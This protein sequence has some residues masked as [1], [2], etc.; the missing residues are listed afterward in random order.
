MKRKRPDELPAER[1]PAGISATVPSCGAARFRQQLPA[2][3]CLERRRISRASAWWTSPRPRRLRM[4]LASRT[5]RP[6]PR[7]P[8]M[9]SRCA[10]VWWPAAETAKACGCSISAGSSAAPCGRLLCFAAR[11]FLSRCNNTPCPSLPVPPGLHDDGCGDQEPHGTRASHEQARQHHPPRR[12]QVHRH[13]EEQLLLSAQLE[14]LSTAAAGSGGA[15]ALCGHR[16]QCCWL[17]HAA[18]AA[19][20]LIV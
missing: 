13:A 14:Q 6:P 20:C 19:A 7:T 1:Q 5:L 17:A 15:W 9:W 16:D 10:L 2:V 11:C 3:S 18:A 8:A 12:G 4:R